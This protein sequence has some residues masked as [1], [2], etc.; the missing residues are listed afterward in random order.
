MNLWKLKMQKAK[1]KISN[2]IKKAKE[3]KYLKRL[4][5]VRVNN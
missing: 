1:T 5:Q 3:A 4:Y 2:T